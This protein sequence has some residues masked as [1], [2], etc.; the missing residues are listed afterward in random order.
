MSSKCFKGF[1]SVDTIEKTGLYGYA[2]G[3]SIDCDVV[4]VDDFI[5]IHK[6]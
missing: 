1:V 6:Y 5:D 2:Y 3:F 4:T